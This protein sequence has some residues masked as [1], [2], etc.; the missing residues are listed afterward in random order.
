[1]AIDLGRLGG[2]FGMDAISSFTTTIIWGLLAVSLVTMI[3]IIIRNKVKYVY[4]GFIFKRRQDDLDTDLQTSKTIQGKAGYF[5]KKGK[6]I[7]RIKFGAM[8]WHQVELTKLPD[9][10][11]MIGNQVYYIQLNKDNYAQAK[12]TI[13]WEGKGRGLSLEPVEDDLKY[14]AKLDLAEKSGILNPKSAFERVA[15]FLVL[16][17][18]IFAGIITMYFIQKGCSA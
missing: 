5:N 13:D 14:G 9:P 12:M 11:F 3:A 1:M 18:I 4:Y 2:L 17:L 10:D 7:F 15:P 6:T 16:G 8:P